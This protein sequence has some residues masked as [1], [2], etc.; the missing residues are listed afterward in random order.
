[1]RFALPW[2]LHKDIAVDGMSESPQSP[3][4]E[5]PTAKPWVQ[6]IGVSLKVGLVLALVYL[7]AVYYQRW[8]R[9]ALE[10][11]KP[12]ERKIPADYYVYPPKSYVSDAESAERNLTGKPLWVKEGYRW[13][14]DPADGLLSPLEK[15][16]PTKIVTRGDDVLL[17]FE[18]DGRPVRLPISAGPRFF[19]DDIFFLKDPR[20]LYNHWPAE[21]WQKIARHDVEVGMT[22][23]QVAFSAGAGSLVRASGDQTVRVIEYTLRESA[24]LPRL[25]VTF[26]DGV[27]EQVEQL[28]AGS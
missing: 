27:A 12:A 20:E 18:R 4:H 11:A 13:K 15:I 23:H 10:R 28:P 1:M 17:E 26:R 25:R 7:G 3:H 21:V 14:A 6:T 16:V 2:L 5:S 8:N 19:V 24:G 22:E 9:P